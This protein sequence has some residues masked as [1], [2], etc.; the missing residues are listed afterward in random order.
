METRLICFL[1]HSYDEGTLEDMGLEISEE[2]SRSILIVSKVEAWYRTIKQ[3]PNRQ[4]GP[5]EEAVL[6]LVIKF[7]TDR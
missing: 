6:Q 2:M 5:V 7:V 4:N 1:I 3:S